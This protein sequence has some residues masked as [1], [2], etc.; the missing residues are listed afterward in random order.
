MSYDQVGDLSD[1]VF[2]GDL[3]THTDLIRPGIPER[4]AT[5]ILTLFKLLRGNL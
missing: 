1:C 5:P 2:R 4:P 3:A